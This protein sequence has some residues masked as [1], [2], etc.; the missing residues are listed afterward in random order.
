M[1]STF[2]AFYAGYG[3]EAT[4]RAKNRYGSLMERLEKVCTWEVHVVIIVG[5]SVESVH[6]K[7]FNDD[8]KLL[9]VLE[10][11]WDDIMR[12]RVFKLIKTKY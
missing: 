2:A 8:I 7:T 3:E 6:A 4:D 5:G 11:K 9:R 1:A 10:S 12:R